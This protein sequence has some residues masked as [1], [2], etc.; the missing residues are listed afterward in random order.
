MPRRAGGAGEHVKYE[1]LETHSTDYSHV[2]R[3]ADTGPH[4]RDYHLLFDEQ[5]DQIFDAIDLLA[6]RVRRV[7]GTTIPSIGHPLVR[8]PPFE[9]MAEVQRFD[10]GGPRS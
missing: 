2:S 5:A 8:Q 9:I 6:E 4:L 7:G 1:G 10:V 3:N